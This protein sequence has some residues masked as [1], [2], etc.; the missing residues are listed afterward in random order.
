MEI[1]PYPLLIG[2]LKD[3]YSPESWQVVNTEYL[4]FWGW[5][6]HCIMQHT[7]QGMQGMKPDLT[8]R[9]TTVRDSE[10]Q[11]IPCN[12]GSDGSV[13]A[14]GKWSMQLVSG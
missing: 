12:G 2:A 10:G 13:R 7:M 1:L 8:R 5:G 4:H 9:C 6:M 3:H 11:A 14:M